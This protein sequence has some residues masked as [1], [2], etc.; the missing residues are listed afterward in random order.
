MYHVCWSHGVHLDL[1]DAKLCDE[2]WR[3]KFFDGVFI[4]GLALNDHQRKGPR[5]SVILFKNLN[6]VLKI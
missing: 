4:L 5:R 2:F 3:K 1:M 6:L